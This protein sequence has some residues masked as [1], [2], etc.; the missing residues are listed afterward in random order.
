MMAAA[1]N[2]APMVAWL[3][4]R[5]ASTEARDATGMCALDIAHGMGAA[6]AVTLLH[7]MR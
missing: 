5:G 3:L 4:E 6:D 1:C 2:R 7:G